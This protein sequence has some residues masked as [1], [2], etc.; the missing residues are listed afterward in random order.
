VL[1]AEALV[2]LALVVAN[3][4]LAMAEA[5]FMAARTERLRERAAAGDAGARAALAFKEEPT[6]FLSTVQVGITLVG[7]LAGAV[8]GTTLAGPLAA[9]LAGIPVLGAYARP[10]AFAAVVG[11]VSYLSLV[12]G[13]LAPKRLALSDPERVAAGA[14][15]PLAALAAALGPVN[16]LLT[17]STGLLL[18]ALP[19]RLGAERPP[20]EE[21]VRA[22][23]AQATRAGVFHAAEE[24]LVHAVFALGDRRVDELMTPRP[25]VVWVDVGD[26]PAE[27][28]RR[29]RESGHDYFPVCRGGLDDVRGVVAAA[30]LW[31]DGAVTGGAGPE[32][33]RP[34]VFVPEHLR[35]LD[36]LE[37]FRRAGAHL[38]LVVDEHGTV[39]GLVTLTDVLEAIVGPVPGVGR[40]GEA[41]PVRREDGSWLLDGAT[42]LVELRR[43]LG[44]PGV[45]AEAASYL[46][47]GGLVQRALDRVPATGDRVE[48]GGW[49]FEVVDMD[50][51]RVDRVL[52]TPVGAGDGSAAAA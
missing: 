36:A 1:L 3:G 16:A 7:V 52:A 49:R 6:R 9:L 5:A 45:G 29:A 30:D 17:V 42:P 15:R 22:L 24:R 4:L 31:P 37:E 25:R 46:T 34:A 10:V 48:S 2:V 19:I 13:E 27:Q 14:A 23:L 43:T 20:S 41:A 21:E 40:P 33:L 35:A 18:R 26:T 44:A 50:G 39:V 38:L 11:A 32:R 12:A 8:G 47:L 51:R 28:R